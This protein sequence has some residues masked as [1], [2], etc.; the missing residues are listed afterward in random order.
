MKSNTQ[1]E[2]V[3]CRPT[4]RGELK[5]KLS[6][7]IPCEVASYAA[8]MTANL[9]RGWLEFDEFVTRPSENEGWTVFEYSQFW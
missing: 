3:F 2:E 9:L 6:V 5:E 8:E 7:G 1:V 4:T